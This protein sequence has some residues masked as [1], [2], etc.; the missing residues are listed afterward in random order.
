MTLRP[1]DAPLRWTTASS[2]VVEQVQAVLDFELVAVTRKRG[3]D[4]VVLQVRDVED[5]WQVGEVGAWAD[6]LCARAFDGRAPRLT[7]DVCAEPG[8]VQAAAALG[9]QTG[10]SVSVPLRDDDGEL[11]G[12]LCALSR[13]SRGPELAAQAPLL[14]AFAQ[15]LGALLTAELRLQPALRAAEQADTVDTLTGLADRLAWDR[16]LAAEERRCVA[17]GLHAAVLAVAVPAL[18]EVSREL[19]HGSGHELLGAVGAVLREICPPDAVLARVGG[20]RVGVLLP[21]TTPAQA[22][23][24]HNGLRAALV[25]RGVAAATGLAARGPAGAV[26][27]WHEAV[28]RTSGVRAGDLAPAPPRTQPWPVQ[29]AGADLLVRELLDLARVQVRAQICFVGEWQGDQRIMRGVSSALPIPAG[30][31]DVEP[32]NGTF[33]QRILD[34]RLPRVIADTSCYPAAMEL[35]VTAA[36]GIGSYIG[37]PVVLSDGSLY[38]TLCCLSQAPDPELSERDA[39]VLTAI[40]ASLARVLEPELRAAQAYAAMAA[41]LEPVLRGEAT[42]MVF[43]PVVSLVDGAV[44]GS[45]ALARFG[46]QAHSTQEWFAD[47]E[48][49]GLT[50]ELEVATAQA[51]LVAGRDLPGF[52]ALNLSATTLC[53]PHLPALLDGVDLARLVV[54]VSEHEQIADY[55][56]LLEVLAPLRAQGLRVAVDDAGAGFA[57]LRHVVLLSPEL[58]KLDISLVQGVDTDRTRQALAAALTG[59]ARSTGAQVVAEGVE[60]EAQRTVLRDAGVTLM[61]GWLESD[62]VG[63]EQ[64]MARW[65]RRAALPA[66]RRSATPVGQGC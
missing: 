39:E 34:G 48:R 45:E 47:A 10:A 36:L 23:V 66:P 18:T 11:L 15:V 55:T 12:S 33:C 40:A 57:S 1:A 17:Y 29:D 3:A 53:S 6:T 65:G 59:F 64:F 13:R 31:G 16:R 60:T 4:V 25:E 9:F 14:E 51:A 44:V 28:G 32:L 42:T 49:A 54:E 7:P 56:A 22:V 24:V 19:G 37:V 21:E 5:R 63:P 26:A 46:G 2:A 58:I 30:R 61:Q 43:Q 20:E 52:L 38:G 62:G 50:C 35:P 41:R 27:A 8:L